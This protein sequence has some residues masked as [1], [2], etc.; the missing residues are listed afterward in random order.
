MKKIPSV[1]ERDWQ[2]DRSRVVAELNPDC[3]WVMRGEGVATRQW[4]GTAVRVRG[5]RLF[6]RADA[7]RGKT[8]PPG[9]EPCEDAPDPHTGH[10]PGWRP[11]HTGPEDQWLQE[12]FEASGG[13]TL[14]DG[15]YE[16]IGPRIGGNPECVDPHRLVRHGAD[17]LRF[18]WA[19]KWAGDLYRN[20]ISY[21]WLARIEGIVW[22]HP[23]G[24]MAKIKR[25]DFGIPWPLPK[26]DQ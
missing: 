15:T 4:D 10:W 14:C 26:D 19:A 23:D 5:G 11:A 8:P 22:H 7:K 18:D 6:A 21:L 3:E 2:G 9:F 13:E 24:R 17:V 16:A 1:L 20:L 25:R 12:A